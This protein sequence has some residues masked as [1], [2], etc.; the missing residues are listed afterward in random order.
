MSELPYRRPERS[1]AAEYYFRY[2]DQV[3][4]SNGG[5]VRGPLVER[6]CR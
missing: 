6:P 3:Q 1:E 4:S 2:I 5:T